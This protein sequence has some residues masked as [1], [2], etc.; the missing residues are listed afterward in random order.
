M[1]LKTVSAF[2]LVAKVASF[3]RAAAEL[4]VAQSVLSRRVAA[5]EQE[6]GGKLFY[7][8]GRG[9]ALTE[10]GVRLQSSARSLIDLSNQLLEEARNVHAVPSGTVDIALVPAVSRLL[11]SALCARLRRDYPR[12]RL[13]VEEAYSGQVEEWLAEGRVEIG[14]FNRYRKGK[15][16]DAEPL[17]SAEMLLVSARGHP[18]TKNATIPLRA[19]ARV[20]LALP[21]RPNSLVTLLATF[22]AN[23]SIDLDILLESGSAAII[24]DAV[25]HSGLC[26]IFPRHAAAPELSDGTFS[27]SRIVKPSIAQVTWLAFGRQRPAT[28]A[29]RVV[30]KLVR[31]LAVEFSRKGAWLGSSTVGVAP[32][33]S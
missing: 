25:K 3:S 33:A 15:V 14:L 6:L 2:H 28:I 1:D 29:A 18:A 16:R 22:A 4:G 32:I 11:V 21:A 27:A 31:E 10:L 13:R 19:L 30:A 23:Q 7:R 5:L 12:L 17:I 24:V 26:T 20:P 8:T 9:V